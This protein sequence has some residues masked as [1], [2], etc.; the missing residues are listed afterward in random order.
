MKRDTL[1]VKGLYL[2]PV[3]LFI[4]FCRCIVAVLHPHCKARTETVYS[5]ASAFHGLAVRQSSQRPSMG[6]WE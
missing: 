4:P 2:S 5:N 6:L 3:P 1:H